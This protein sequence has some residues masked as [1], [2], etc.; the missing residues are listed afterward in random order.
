MPSPAG[1][2]ASRTHI[3][4]TVVARG[5]KEGALERYLV[6]GMAGLAALAALF[7]SAE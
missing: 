6:P 4:V 1:E 2:I 7:L 3:P 5:R